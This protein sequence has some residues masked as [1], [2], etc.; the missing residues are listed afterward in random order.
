[1]R[2]NQKLNYPYN[3]KGTC[4]IKVTL[5][6]KENSTLELKETIPFNTFMQEAN[7]FEM[8]QGNAISTS[9][10]FHLCDSPDE[11][12]LDLC[13]PVNCHRKYQGPRGLFDT[14]DRRCVP[15]P[16]CVNAID[17]KRITKLYDLYENDCITVNDS[18]SN[19][20]IEGILRAQGQSVNNCKGVK[21]ADNLSVQSKWSSNVYCHHG[22]IDAKT[23][24]CVCE[25]G[26]T[27]FR[28]EHAESAIGISTMPVHMCTVK[29]RYKSRWTCWVYLLDFSNTSWK[30]FVWA[31]GLAVLWYLLT[32][33]SVLACYSCYRLLY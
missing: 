31:M 28:D 4:T 21:M 7:I 22:K 15:I 3:R 10:K 20:E 33:I 30:D 17:N 1:M 8:Q 14:T 16:V 26:W 12:I 32:Y 27:S 24:T 29:I 23:G 25:N 5:S 9:K 11:D 18:V 6:N 2:N 13:Q 19:S